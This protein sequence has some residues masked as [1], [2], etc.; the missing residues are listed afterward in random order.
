VVPIKIGNADEITER[1]RKRRAAHLAD[2]GAVNEDRFA[3]FGRPRRVAIEREGHERAL[4]GAISFEF[5]DDFLARVTAFF[6]AD[7]VTFKCG[8]GQPV[9]RVHVDPEPRNTGFDAEDVLGLRANFREFEIA[10]GVHE[11]SQQRLPRPRFRYEQES[12]FAGFGDAKREYFIAEQFDRVTAVHPGG[13]V[14]GRDSI[15]G[16]EDGREERRR[17]R[18]LDQKLVDTV[19]VIVDLGFFKEKVLIEP[20]KQAR[21]LLTFDDHPI[22]VFPTMQREV[23]NKMR[24]TIERGVDMPLSRFEL[25]DVVRSL[26]LQPG[27][28]VGAGE[29]DE[30]MGI[31][32]PK[33]H[34]LANGVN[35]LFDAAH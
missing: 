11:R 34:V 19:T 14:I 22:F 29:A 21:S 30:C 6:V 3:G 32:Q 18:T 20:F 9:R 2:F 25:N 13:Q 35:L 12:V 4:R 28:G 17:F 26:R 7:R 31:T 27:R 5:G 10:A 1:G 8:F 15:A 24:F 16:V 23:T 33:A